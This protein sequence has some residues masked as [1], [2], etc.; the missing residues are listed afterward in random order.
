MDQN[1]ACSRDLFKALLVTDPGRVFGK[2]IL[3]F[4]QGSVEDS[5][6]L[7]ALLNYLLESILKEVS[8]CLHFHLE[9][10]CLLYVRSLKI[11]PLT[12]LLLKYI[13]WR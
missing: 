1:D 7:L 12:F 10:S 11:S 4:L 5:V 13:L 9:G 2:L 6:R 8:N 3:R